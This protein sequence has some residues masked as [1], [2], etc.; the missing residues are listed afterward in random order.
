M[1]I[2]LLIAISGPIFDF[3]SAPNAAWWAC[4]IC[5]QY[6]AADSYIWADYFFGKCPQC[7]RVGQL[8]MC[9][10]LPIATPGP[11]KVL[12]SVT[13]A[14]GWAHHICACGCR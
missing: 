3:G 2:W 12:G 6:V 5:I 4:C 11:I 1:C 7:N 8:H 9:M 10:W 13:K 14:I